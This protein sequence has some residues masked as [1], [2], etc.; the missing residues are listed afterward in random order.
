MSTLIYCV[1]DEE[2]I[3]GLVSYVLQGQ[4]YRVEAFGDSSGLWDALESELPSLI[5]LDI[6]LDGEDGLTILQ[7]LRSH[8]LYKKIPVIMLTAKTTE[9]DIVKGL[10]SGADDYISKPFGVVELVSRIKAVLRRTQ[11]STNLENV[12][13][14]QV[15][16]LLIEPKRHRV[17]LNGENLN[18]SLKEYE[19]LLYLITNKGIVLKRNQLMQAVWGFNYEGETRTVDMHIMNLRQKLGNMGSSIKTVRGVGY[20]WEY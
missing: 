15:G 1:E 16:N 7:K 6:M 11:A 2:S 8:A 12:N 19:L 10:D 4:Q 13:N 5:L 14:I 9:F 17:T 20:M 3:R 18:V